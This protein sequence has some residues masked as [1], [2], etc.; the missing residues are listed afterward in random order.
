MA[1]ELITQEEISNMSE[2]EMLAWLKELD[3]MEECKRK[4]FQ[5][6]ALH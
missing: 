1:L 3:A 4:A 6:K 5:C 2:A